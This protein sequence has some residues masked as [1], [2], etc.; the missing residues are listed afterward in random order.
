VARMI[1]HQY[2][3]IPVYGSVV[4]PWGSI[5]ELLFLG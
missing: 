4:D 1:S 2:D 3:G 5:I